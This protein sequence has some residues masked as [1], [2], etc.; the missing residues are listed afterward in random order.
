MIE[1][2]N[3]DL[4]RALLGYEFP[5]H[6]VIQ[7]LLSH[8]QFFIHIFHWPYLTYESWCGSEVDT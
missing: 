3:E 5:G 7:G 8:F 6:C 2:Q 1:F 4:E